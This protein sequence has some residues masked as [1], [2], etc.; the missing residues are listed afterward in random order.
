ME[1][2]K[3]IKKN[4][5]LHKKFYRAMGGFLITLVLLCAAGGNLFAKYYAGQKNKGVGVASSLYFSSNVLKNV[6]STE[7][8]T[9]YPVIFNTE[10]WDGTKECKI[11]VDICNY[12]NQL[13]YNDDNLDIT[14]DISFQLRDASDGGTYDVTYGEEKQTISQD[15]TVTFQGKTLKGGNPVTDHFEISVTRPDSEKENTKYRSDG[16]IVTATPVSPSYVTKS[17]KLGGVIYASMLSAAY[18]LDHAFKLDSGAAVADYSGFPCTITYTPG[19]DQAAHKVKVSWR[20]DL[21]E[22]DQ[23][24]TYYQKAKQDTGSIGTEEGTDDMQWQ[25]MIIIMQPYSSIEITFYRASKDF[26]DSSATLDSYVT[27]QDMDKTT[28]NSEGGGNS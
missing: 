4:R 18:K 12:A 11:T 14:Y 19:E 6:A 2:M 16:I 8:T 13:L 7:D 10:P 9:D 26:N 15:N 1:R 25:Y 28:T 24:N 27:L 20:S 3:A 17:A 5:K 23:F 21:L 22:I